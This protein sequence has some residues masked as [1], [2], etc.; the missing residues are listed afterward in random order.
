MKNPGKVSLPAVVLI[1]SFTDPQI[2]LL[3]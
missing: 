3:L 2:V 1:D